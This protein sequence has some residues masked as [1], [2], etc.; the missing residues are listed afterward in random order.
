MFRRIEGIPLVKRLSANMKGRDLFVTDIHGCYDMLEEL[1]LMA[2]FDE[3]KDRLLIGGDLSDRGPQPKAWVDLLARD[4]AH[5]IRGNHDQMI[6][7]A[8][9][10]DAPRVV[11][12]LKDHGGQWLLDMIEKN[13][14]D[15]HY[16]V[17]LIYHLPIAMEV[18]GRK[19]EKF[20]FVHAHCPYDDWNDL[21]RNLENPASDHHLKNLVE[22]CMWDRRRID[23][24]ETHNIENVDTIFV[25]HTSVE[26][27]MALGNVYF[28]DTGAVFGNEL[29][30]HDI[31][32]GSIWSLASEFD[33]RKKHSSHEPWSR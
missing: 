28:C 2:E 18:E 3:N 20:G 17:D 33:F 15:L 27:P 16:M 14:P 11:A 4:Y 26:K 29:S 25:G 6:I 24:K 7:D 8:C 32:T 30:L 13:D 10:G 22:A 31:N 19:G 9:E 1:L 23:F 12:I 21:I 5:C